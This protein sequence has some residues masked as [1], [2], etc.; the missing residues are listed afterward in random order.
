MTFDRYYNR[1]YE[2]DAASVPDEPAAPNATGIVRGGSWAQDA[3][4]ARA[5][6]RSEI[7]PDETEAF[8]GFRCAL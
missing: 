5:S 6:N 7:Y 4:V 2:E 3:R 1:Y 8:V